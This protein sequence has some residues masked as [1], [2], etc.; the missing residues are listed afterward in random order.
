[1]VIKIKACINDDQFNSNFEIHAHQI[2]VLF[3]NMM[4]YYKQSMLLLKFEFN[5]YLL[6]LRGNLLKYREFYQCLDKCNDIR[7]NQIKL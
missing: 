1:M 7:K 5:M 6:S 3:K 2:V 4:K